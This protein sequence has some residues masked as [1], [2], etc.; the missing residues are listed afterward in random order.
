MRLLIPPVVF[1]TA[2]YISCHV[3]TW[4]GYS[5]L[6]VHVYGSAGNVAGASTEIW[7]TAH[8]ENVLVATQKTDSDGLTTFELPAGTSEVRVHFSASM[9][10]YVSEI[11]MLKGGE[12][13]RVEVCTTCD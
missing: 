1:L 5:Y 3:N 4:T 8:D 10:D 11:V 12:T 2:T 7:S 9:M 6:Q 13:R